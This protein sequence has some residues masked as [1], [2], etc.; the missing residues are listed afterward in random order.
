MSLTKYWPEEIPITV[1]REAIPNTVEP[2][3]RAQPINDNRIKFKTISAR[4]QYKHH[5]N[6]RLM[7]NRRCVRI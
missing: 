4:F 3:A 6:L 1:K 7:P 2:I 5:R